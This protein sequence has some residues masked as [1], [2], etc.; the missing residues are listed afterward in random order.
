MMIVLPDEEVEVNLITLTL[1]ERLVP[2]QSLFL[3]YGRMV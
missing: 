2:L 3:F 1:K